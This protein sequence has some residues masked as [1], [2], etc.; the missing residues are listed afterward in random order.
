M[1][2]KQIIDNLHPSKQLHAQ[3]GEDENEQQQK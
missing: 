1:L 2:A 3:Q